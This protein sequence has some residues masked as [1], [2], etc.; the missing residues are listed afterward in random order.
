MKFCEYGPSTP[1]YVSGGSEAKKKNDNIMV[2]NLTL[3]IPFL[4]FGSVRSSYF[5]AN[6]HLLLLH[7]ITIATNP[8]AVFLVVCDP[9]LNESCERPR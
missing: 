6:Y 1:A 2:T 4:I 5:Q 3:T 8:E 7:L 9:S